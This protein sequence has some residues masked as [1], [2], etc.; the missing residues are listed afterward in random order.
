MR[1]DG[2]HTCYGKSHVLRGVDLAV[3]N[4]EIVALLGR[5]G[6][7]KT[8][9]LNTIMGFVKARAGRIIFKERDITQ[10]PTHGISRLG[11]GYVPQGRHLFPRM[12]VLENLKTGMIRSGGKGTLERILEL[13]PNLR[14]RLHQRAGSLSGGEQQALAISRAILMEP[15]LLMLDEPTT[16]LMPLFVHSLQEIIRRL[17]QEGLTILLIEEK[18]PFALA[19]AHRVNFMVK[20]R[21]KYVAAKEDLKD[22]REVFLKYLGVEA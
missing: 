19:L 22:A 13:F 6:V 14:G 9:T 8:T 18:V 11:I 20:G 17:N 2:I 5:N 16:G 10:L 15:E 1:L 4:G 3:K 7:G 21:I 12:T